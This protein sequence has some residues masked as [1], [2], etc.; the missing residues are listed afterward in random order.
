MRIG[1]VRTA[2]SPCRCAEALARGL[3]S[4]GHE[5]WM[6]DSE[7]IALRASEMARQCDLVIDH[8]DTF[9]GRGLFRPLIRHLL[10]TQGSRIVGSDAKA[11]FLAD[12][13]ITSK[14]RLAEAGIPV[15]PGMVVRS[16]DWQLPQWL[17][18]PLVLKPAYEHMSR[19]LCLVGTDGEAHAMA[20]DLLESLHQPVLVEKYI[21]GRELAVSLLEGPDGLEVLPPL[22]WRVDGNGTE[23]LS[24][25]FKL[26]DP[27]GEEFGERK[28]ALRADLP[29]D[30]GKD[31]ESLVRRAFQVLGLRDYARFDIRL[32]PGG[33]FFFLEA[34]TTPSLEPLEALALSARWAGMDYPGLV[35]RMLSA[36]LKRHQDRSMVNEKQMVIDL[37]SG[38]LYLTVPEG[39]HVPP[40]SSIELA[41]LLDVKRGEEV[42]EL[43][44]GAGLLSIA[45]AKLGAGSVMATDIDPKALQAT[46]LNGR[47]NG[48][49]DRIQA[50]AGS[51]YDALENGVC[52]P[53]DA[54]LA[55]P[56]Q[57]PGPRPFGP[58]YGGSDGTK[59]LFTVVD[60]ASAFLK[61]GGRLW[62]LAISLANPSALLKRLGEKFSSVS[63]VRQTERLFTTKEY[64]SMEEGLFSHFQTL[65]AS[66]CS[67]FREA[68]PGKYLFLNLFIRAEGR[69]ST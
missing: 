20:S 21:N 10:E 14:S 67:E 25:A 66:G 4:L 18:P 29:I 27:V 43:G 19:G 57:T 7:E 22:E 11:C 17:P 68:D 55:T 1:I 23:I 35:R 8:T 37:P 30:L 28:E 16:K 56:P 40:L 45:A 60:G 53:F 15:P 34:N 47:R 46:L 36:A 9:H 65:Y 33:T 41:R 59:H 13:K 49:E 69:R 61:P 6:A 50:R 39:V 44:C 26:I 24:E 51:W 38:P 3:E 31:L 62:L 32:S 2:D 54:I 5:Y 48:M 52:G 58:R 63:I 64:E 42:L 12:D